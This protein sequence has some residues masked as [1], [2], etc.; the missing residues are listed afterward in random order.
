MFLN[1]SVKCL[2]CSF[3][4][5]LIAVMMSMIPLMSAMSL[6]TDVLSDFDI[7]DVLADRDVRFVF[8]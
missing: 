2:L 7:R 5:A 1:V 3:G 8:Q 4:M 6:M